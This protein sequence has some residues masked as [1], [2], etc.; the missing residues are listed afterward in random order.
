MTEEKCTRRKKKKE[1]RS[2]EAAIWYYGDKMDCFQGCRQL[3][4]T[5]LSPLSLML[6]YLKLSSRTRVRETEVR[7]NCLMKMLDVNSRRWQWVKE[8]KRSNQTPPC[9]HE[10]T[11]LTRPNSR[12]TLLSV[13]C[14]GYVTQLAL[15]IHQWRADLV[16]K[17]RLVLT[18]SMERF[19]CFFFFATCTLLQR[20]SNTVNQSNGIGD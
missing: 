10:R 13:S 11:T 5:A 18:S 9:P 3:K 16:C 8:S 4:A 14:Q 17:S 7:Q 12:H 19:T 15:P 1:E 2:H 6:Y 20:P